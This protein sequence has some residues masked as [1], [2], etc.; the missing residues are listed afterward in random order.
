L[1]LAF[2]HCPK[3]SSANGATDFVVPQQLANIIMLGAVASSSTP[4]K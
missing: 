2:A 4:R 1:I 3:C